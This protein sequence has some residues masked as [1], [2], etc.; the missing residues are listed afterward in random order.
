VRYA[1]VLGRREAGVQ[2]IIDRRDA[3]R[4]KALF[5]ALA[6]SRPAIEAAFGAPLRWERLD[7]HRRCRVSWT[8][9]IASLD[10]EANWPAVQDVLIDAMIR[11]AGAFDPHL[12]ALP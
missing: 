8:T 2:V 7:Q 5:D 4:S 11:L 12:A 1:Y 6:A 9:P 3:A 10:V